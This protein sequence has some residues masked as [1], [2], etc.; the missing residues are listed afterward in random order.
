M[1]RYLRVENRNIIENIIYKMKPDHFSIT[2]KDL[3]DWMEKAVEN[4]SASAEDFSKLNFHEKLC[5]KGIVKND[6]YYTTGNGILID[7][8]K[9]KYIQLS[10]DFYKYCCVDIFEI[11]PELK[12]LEKLA[13]FQ[14]DALYDY[15]F[16]SDIKKFPNFTQ[17]EWEDFLDE[18][19]DKKALE[20]TEKI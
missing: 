14:L 9:R 13:D 7:I 16:I 8:E 17:E 15:Y 12:K 3:N 19:I 5:F 20:W 2:I 10:G 11:I 1:S 6:D 4:Y 18:A